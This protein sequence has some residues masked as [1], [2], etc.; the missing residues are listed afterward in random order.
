MGSV[1]QEKQLE[2]GSKQ[3]GVMSGEEGKR[4]TG[5]HGNELARADTR[6]PYKRSQMDVEIT[7][8]SCLAVLSI[9]GLELVVS[10]HPKLGLTL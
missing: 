8:S 3:D 6:Q 4:E 5:R 10:I 2:T 1:K 7:S 9:D